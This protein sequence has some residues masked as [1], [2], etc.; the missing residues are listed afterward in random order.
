MSSE[1]KGVCPRTEELFERFWN[2][3]EDPDHT[4][5]NN[6]LKLV[7]RIVEGPWMLTAAVT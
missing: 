6:R 2:D 7:P 4:F 3:T 5:R 1:E